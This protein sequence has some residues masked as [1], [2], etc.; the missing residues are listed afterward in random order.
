[1]PHL[2]RVLVD[3]YPVERRRVHGDAAH[4]AQVA[5]L[6]GI[7]EVPAVEAVAGRGIVRQVDEHLGGWVQN[8]PS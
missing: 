6:A 8:A 1:M 4:Q 2:A 5:L 7:L 3:V